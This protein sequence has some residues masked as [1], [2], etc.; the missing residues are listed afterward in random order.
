MDQAQTEGRLY[1]IEEEFDATPYCDCIYLV[2]PNCGRTGALGEKLCRTTEARRE[3]T[4]GRGGGEL[5]PP[6]VRQWYEANGYEPR[7]DRE[8]MGKMGG[9]DGEKEEYT[10]EEEGG[11]N[12]EGSRRHARAQK[13]AGKKGH[14]RRK[15]GRFKQLF[16]ALGGYSTDSSSSTSGRFS[17]SS[18][19]ESDT[20][21]NPQDTS[22][23]GKILIVAV[24]VANQDPFWNKLGIAYGSGLGMDSDDSEGEGMKSCTSPSCETAR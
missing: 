18:A 14:Q 15:S 11:E 9:E 1:D 13:R 19:S 12:E 24:P 7:H 23:L 10:G 5:L 17:A 16:S 21:P 20:I 22:S 2:T 8:K 6:D 3:P 4:L